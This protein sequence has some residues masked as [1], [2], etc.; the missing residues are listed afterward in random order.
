MRLVYADET[1]KELFHYVA[2]VLTPSDAKRVEN[3]VAGLAKVYGQKYRMKP[4]VEFKGSWIFGSK[5]IWQV[6]D[7][8][9]QA[10]LDIFTNLAN[11]T[12]EINP[13]VIVKT[14]NRKG[15]RYRYSN[16]EKVQNVAFRHLLQETEKL[17]RSQNFHYSFF[18]DNMSE[19]TDLIREVRSY[20]AFGTPADYKKEYLNRMIDIPHFPDSHSSRIIQYVDVMAYLFLKY[21]ISHSTDELKVLEKDLAEIWRKSTSHLTPIQSPTFPFT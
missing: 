16:P 10:K 4:R 7:N 1:G 9:Q 3:N 13:E 11:I 14:V 6:L 2:F 12:L 15:L 5:G 17:A 20:K 19:R 18:A 21:R 8:D